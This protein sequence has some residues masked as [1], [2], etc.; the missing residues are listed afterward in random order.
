[1][2][3]RFKYTTYEINTLGIEGFVT[4]NPNDILRE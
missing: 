4:G 3:K 1:M 2:I